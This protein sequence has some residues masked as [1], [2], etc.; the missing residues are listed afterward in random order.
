MNQFLPQV[1]ALT[2]SRIIR[3][4]YQRYQALAR[5]RGREVL[6]RLGT[7]TILPSSRHALLVRGSF[8]RGDISKHSDLDLVLLN[9]GRR[10]SLPILQEDGDGLPQSSLEIWRL[11]ASSGREKLGLLLSATQARFLIGS[12]ATFFAFR[13]R[14]TTTLRGLTPQAL[15]TMREKD[16]RRHSGFYDQSSEFRQ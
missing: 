6:D 13:E 8:A 16:P 12:Q 9:P 11:G 4:K 7:R 2:G 5:L 1:T 3:C 15:F 10:T 14:C